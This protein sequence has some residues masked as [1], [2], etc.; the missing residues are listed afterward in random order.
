MN[1]TRFRLDS[2]QIEVLDDK[3]AWILKKKSHLERLKCA[4]DI[5]HSARLQI[6]FYIKSLH[7]EWDEE[8]VQKEVARRLSHGAV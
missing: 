3:V 4:F 5:W 1:K 7:P 2:G 8:K 6:A